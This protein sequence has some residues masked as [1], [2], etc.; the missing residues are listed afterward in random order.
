MDKYDIQLR[1]LPYNPPKFNSW[2]KYMLHFIYPQDK[3]WYGDFEILKDIKYILSD[4]TI[5]IVPSDYKDNLQAD[6]V[7]GGFRTGCI[8]S[9]PLYEAT[10]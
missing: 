10:S 2:W 3:K 6:M 1:Y 4:G 8:S 7:G 9:I 5:I